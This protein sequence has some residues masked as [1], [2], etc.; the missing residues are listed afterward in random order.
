[1]CI[2][3]IYK[4]NATLLERNRV[5]YYFCYLD[6]GVMVDDLSSMTEQDVSFWYKKDIFTKKRRVVL[7][8]QFAPP[9]LVITKETCLHS[10]MYKKYNSFSNTRGL[11]DFM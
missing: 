10:S 3:F 4:I 8:Y 9:F 11:I 6:S 1:M 7:R 2:Y 5:K